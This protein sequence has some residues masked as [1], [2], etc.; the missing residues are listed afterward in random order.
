MHNII[1]LRLYAW[2]PG[3][4]PDYIL[5]RNLFILI[6][7]HCTKELRHTTLGKVV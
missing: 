7:E 6:I 3:N 5:N 2:W 4:S 1:Q